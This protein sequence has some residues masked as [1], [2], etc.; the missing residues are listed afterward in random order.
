M[1]GL[2]TIDYAQFMVE[3]IPEEIGNI[4]QHFSIEIS[5]VMRKP[6]GHF[7]RAPG[8]VLDILSSFG[9]GTFFEGQGYWK[10]V[11]E[12]VIYILISTT[13]RTEDIISLLRSKISSAQ[14]RLKQQEAFVKINGTTFVG[15]MLDKSVT[16]QFPKQWEFDSDMKKI[17]ANQSRSD[18]HYN[19]IYGRVDYERGKFDDA[20][21]KWTDMIHEFAQKTS[22]SQ[23]EQR[24]LLKCYSNILSPKLS[25]GDE[26]VNQICSQFNKLLPPNENSRFSEMTLSKHAEGRMRGNRLKLYHS[27]GNNSINTEELIKDGFFAIDQIV[28]HFDQGISPYLE[29][30]PIQDIGTIIKHIL[31]INDNEKSRLTQK[32]NELID[33]FPA[34]ENEFR[35]MII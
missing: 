13:G 3:N 35:E 26:F 24:D 31:K 2:D 28:N 5:I 6:K 19:L 27:I 23:T 11:Q 21:K 15:N 1:G 12:P 25:I 7:S 8:V 17:T 4:W 18:E 9:G 16:D 20:Q 22:L 32:L 33:R 30:D 34:Y 10:G 29:K 14:S